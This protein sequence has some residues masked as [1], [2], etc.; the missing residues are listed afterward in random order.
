MTEVLKRLGDRHR[1][2]G[3]GEQ[4]VVEANG[5]RPGSPCVGEAVDDH[6]AQHS[7]EGRPKRH[8][9][10]WAT[11]LEHPVAAGL[12]RAEV[13]YRTEQSVN[14]VATKDHRVDDG[15]G[16]SDSHAA[17][18]VRLEGVD[19]AEHVEKVGYSGANH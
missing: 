1:A 10:S 17:P 15:E 16:N 13:G 9:E 12:Q 14:G 18:L 8:E 7:N 6:V 11:V 4:R 2:I 5:L 19:K 3:S